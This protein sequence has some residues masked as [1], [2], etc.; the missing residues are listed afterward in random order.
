MSKHILNQKGISLVEVMVAAGISAVIALGTMKI[1]ENS[2]KGMRNVATKAALTNFMSYTFG[3][4]LA[5]S[6]KCLAAFD[7]DGDG[8]YGDTVTLVAPGKIPVEGIQ[9]DNVGLGRRNEILPNTNG[10]YLIAGIE[11][12][13]INDTSCQ[14]IYSLSRNDTVESAPGA[15]DNAAK[16]IGGRDKKEYAL[17]GCTFSGTGDL[18]SCSSRGISEFGK[19][20]YKENGREWLEDDYGFAVIGTTGVTGATP[21]VPN[22]KF[23]IMPGTTSAW[24]GLVDGIA[25][26]ANYVLRWGNPLTAG[27]GVAIYGDGANCVTIKSGANAPHFSTCYG[28]PGTTTING[29]TTVNGTSSLNGNTT[30]TGTLGV[31]SNT[32]IGGTTT[33]GGRLTVSSGG[34]GISGNTTVTGTLGVSSNTTIGGTTTSG[35]RLTVSSGGAGISGNSS[36]TG[37]LG[38]S[39][40]TTVGGTLG[41]SG[42]TTIGGNL[43]VSG[44]TT[45]GGRLTVSGGG[46]GITG[47]TNISGNTNIS[48][49]LTV[50]STASVTS[51]IRSGGTG[52]FQRIFVDTEMSAQT[53]TERSDRRLKTNIEPLSGSLEELL[54]LEPVQY[55]WANPQQYGDRKKLGFIAQDLQKTYPELVHEDDGGFLSVNYTGLIAPIIDS[56]KEIYASVMGNSEELEKQ[57]REI[58]ALKKENDE[59][60]ARLDRIEKALNDK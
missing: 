41:V 43:S 30:V 33:S 4:G 22:A 2:Q 46:A 60:K 25:M 45:S 1:N 17:L 38:V 58:A 12:E 27:D 34:A 15:Q 18:T 10:E 31:S 11:F 7:M 35:G 59:L 23:S 48:G 39:S 8:A 14:V 28:T 24:Q 50:S 5:D 3:N 19:W 42:N 55:N 52:Y 16:K 36:I 6:G 44:T 20:Q 40:N 32:T 49:A 21:N 9:G 53:V 57:K 51:T 37:T 47:T 56:I 29:N 13:R 26:P 54:G